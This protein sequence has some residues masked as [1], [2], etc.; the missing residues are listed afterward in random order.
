MPGAKV[1]MDSNILLYT[2]DLTATDKSVA[3]AHWLRSAAEIGAARTN[4]QVL[5]EVTHVM[6]RKRR[7]LSMDEV[8]EAVDSIAFLGQS[9]VTAST[10]QLARTIRANTAYSWWDCLLLASAL[11]LNCTHFLSEDLQD[12]Q[13]IQGLTI[14]SPFAHSPDQILVSR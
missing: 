2:R 14:V 12:S 4:L 13:T 9:P 6:L 10:T 7:D 11:E 1:F 3:S 5:N 8:F